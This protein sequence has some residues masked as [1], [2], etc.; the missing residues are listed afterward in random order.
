MGF[1]NT[2]GV[3]TLYDSKKLKIPFSSTTGTTSSD[4]LILSE[5]VFHTRKAF[6]KEVRIYLSCTFLPQDVVPNDQKFL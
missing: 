2:L 6:W 5:R 4:T 3:V 1:P